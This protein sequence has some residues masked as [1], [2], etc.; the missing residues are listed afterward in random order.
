MD[1][2]SLKGNKPFSMALPLNLNLTDILFK[3]GVRI[4]YDLVMDFQAD[5]IPVVVGY[6]GDVPQQQ[7]LLGFITLS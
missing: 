3:Y 6:K 4:N 7:L 5:K 2:D 1:M